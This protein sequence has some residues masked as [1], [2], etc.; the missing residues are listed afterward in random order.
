[1]SLRTLCIG[2]HVHKL[3]ATV[4]LILLFSAVSAVPAHAQRL[5]F[6]VGAV[7]GLPLT[8]MLGPAVGPGTVSSS[9]TTLPAYGPT[10]SMTFDDRLSVELDAIFKPIHFQRE[11]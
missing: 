7:A 5:S 9:Q 11:T 8:Y 4:F 6:D 2:V 3:V 1:M 10:I